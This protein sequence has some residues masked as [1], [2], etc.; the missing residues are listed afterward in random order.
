MKLRKSAYGILTL[1]VLVFMNPNFNAFDFFP[2]FI[3][4][5]I[6]AAVLSRASDIVPHF[7]EAQSGFLKAGVLS[8]VRLPAALIMYANLLKYMKAMRNLRKLVLIM[9]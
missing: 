3:G 2:D 4:A 6:I 9:R 7:A 8:L 1:S 5:F